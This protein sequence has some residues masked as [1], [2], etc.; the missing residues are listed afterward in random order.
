MVMKKNGRIVIKPSCERLC[1]DIGC[2]SGEMKGR[3]PNRMQQQFSLGL[4][5]W[6]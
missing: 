6:T 4:N 1:R 2:D 3:T 5:V